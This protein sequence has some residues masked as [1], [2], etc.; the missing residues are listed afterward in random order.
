VNAEWIGWAS[1]LVLL[2]TLVKQVWKQ[3]RTETVAGVSRWLYRGQIAASAGFV[4]YSAMLH[5]WVFIATN[6]L[7]F[8]SAV[9]GAVIFHRNRRRSYLQRVPEGV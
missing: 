2:A 8:L 5:N 9:A 6:A 1:S 3:Y 4:A 7:G